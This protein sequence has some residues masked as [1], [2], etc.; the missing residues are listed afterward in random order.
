MKR[1]KLVSTVFCFLFLSF[2]FLP[3]SAFAERIIMKDGTVYNG[4]IHLK[5]KEHI[6]IVEDLE[7]IKLKKADISRIISNEELEQIQKK[8]NKA[9]K[10]NK[11]KNQKTEEK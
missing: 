6:F 2:S 1:F 5:E 7:I 11:K 8:E 3:V 4:N 9:K 10:K